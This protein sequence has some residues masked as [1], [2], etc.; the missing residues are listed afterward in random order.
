MESPFR[1]N[2]KWTGLGEAGKEK[3]ILPYL[4][5]DVVGA[6]TIEKPL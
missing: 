2:W 4:H 6:D 5:K 1:S 3:F